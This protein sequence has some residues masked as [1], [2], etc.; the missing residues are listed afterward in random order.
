[1]KLLFNNWYGRKVRELGS[2][3]EFD[4]EARRG[5]DEH[6]KEVCALNL[7]RAEAAVKLAS[8]SWDKYRDAHAAELKAREHHRRSQTAKR[9]DARKE[10]WEAFMEARVR[11]DMA[12]SEAEQLRRK[13]NEPEL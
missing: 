5:K 4:R 1:M 12:M 6:K 2:A 8:E 9:A 13:S 7:R 3:L 10:A 11:R